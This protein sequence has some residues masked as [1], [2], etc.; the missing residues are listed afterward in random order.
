MAKSGLDWDL[1]SIQRLDG[2]RYFGIE[3]R[4]DCPRIYFH[5]ERKSGR[6]L[7]WVGNALGFPPSRDR[8]NGD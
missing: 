6:T 7:F 4:I 1:N 2:N 3:F 5:D 8:M